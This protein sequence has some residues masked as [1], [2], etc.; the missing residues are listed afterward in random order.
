MKQCC[1][2]IQASQPECCVDQFL[3]IHNIDRPVVVHVVDS[4]CDAERLIYDPLHV[5]DIRCSIPVDVTTPRSD[6][7]RGANSRKRISLAV[8]RRTV[9]QRYCC[10]ARGELCT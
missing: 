10:A 5:N 7:C 4:Q 3:D 6:R 8:G 9:L 1:S 2:L